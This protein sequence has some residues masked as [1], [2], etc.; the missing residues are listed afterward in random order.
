MGLYNKLE[1]NFVSRLK[2]RMRLRSVC[3]S[4]GD[5]YYLI[6]EANMFTSLFRSP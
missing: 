3:V 1:Y 6:F 5:L 4:H 2:L